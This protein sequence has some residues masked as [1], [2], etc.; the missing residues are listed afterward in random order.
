VRLDFPEIIPDRK[1][2]LTE[3]VDLQ[4]TRIYAQLRFQSTARAFRGQQNHMKK[5][6]PSVKGLH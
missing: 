3:Y 5:S 6:L 2:S 1:Q 4:H